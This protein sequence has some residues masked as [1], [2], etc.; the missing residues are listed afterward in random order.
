DGREIKNGDYM[1]IVD[2][3]II[4]TDPDVATAAIKM[5]TEMLDE[6]SEI[7]TILTGQDSSETVVEQITAAVEAIDDEV[8]VQVYAGGQPVYP[9]LI[10]VE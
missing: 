4:V 2:G 1:G 7:V 5:V 8:E 9:Y 3:K 10:S 6:D